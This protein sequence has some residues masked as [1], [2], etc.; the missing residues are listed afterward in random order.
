MAVDAGNGDAGVVGVQGCKGLGIG[1]LVAVVHLLEHP[2]AQLIDQGHEVGADQPHVLVEPGGDVAHDVEIERDLLPQAGALHL[3]RHLVAVEQHTP[4]HLAEG[5]GGDGLPFQLRING[6]DRG[7]EVF[8]DAG[9]G[10]GGI[11][12]GQL[13]LQA[14]QF[15][16][17]KWRHDVR[18]S[19]EGLAGLDEGGAQGGHQIRGFLGTG[20][21]V[22]A[23]LEFAGEPVESHP[24]QIEADGH[25]GLPEAPDQPLGMARVDAGDGG[26]VVAEQAGG[27]DEVAQVGA[28]RGGSS[29]CLASVRE[30]CTACTDLCRA[31]QL[32]HHG[33]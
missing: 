4:V 28:G 25:Q 5:G 26:R 18:P 15:I 29:G 19:R 31:L 17:Q 21:G 9:H 22:V 32:G 24:Q 2:L 12:A 14:R 8:L 3:H 27:L 13:V 33:C 30:I 6:V 7:A 16:Q 11:E 20:L 23:V 10:Q 1:G